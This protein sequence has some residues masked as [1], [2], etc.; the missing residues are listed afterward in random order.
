MPAQNDLPIW[1]VSD[2]ILR[3]TRERSRLVLVAPT[4]SGKTTQ[5]PQMMLDSG[6]AGAKRVM[7]PSE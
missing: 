7:R 6:M 1:K 5:V 3:H 4:G 2:A